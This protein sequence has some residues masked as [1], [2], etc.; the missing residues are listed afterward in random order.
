MTISNIG[1]FFKIRFS[2]PLSC[3][4]TLPQLC[5]RED[6]PFEELS[7][8][9]ACVGSLLLAEK[10][11]YSTVHGQKAVTASEERA[12]RHER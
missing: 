9:M 5:F 8:L 10:E 2:S 1:F 4:E 3:L 6:K 7:S 11:Q 12:N